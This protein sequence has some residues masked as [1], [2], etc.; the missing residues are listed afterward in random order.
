MSLKNL[1]NSWKKKWDVK[2]D[3]RMLWIFFIFAITGS[4]T[5][6]VRKFLFSLLGIQPENAILAFLFKLLAIYIV[7]QI[8][9]F[10]IG[11]LLGEN[12]FVS[13]FLLKM[14]RRL[15]PWRRT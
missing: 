9:L 2:S 7:Y 5:V 14:N 1:W 10:L 15:I 3:R 13:W 4:S 6:V 11:S 8:L 12:K